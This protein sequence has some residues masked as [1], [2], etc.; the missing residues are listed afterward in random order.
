MR[1]QSDGASVIRW[2]EIYND[3]S[4][5]IPPYAV[6][7]VTGV[8]EGSNIFLVDQPNADSQREI[9][10]NGPI[11]VPAGFYGQAHRA[12]PC[13]VLYETADGTPASGEDWGTKNGSW[14]IHKGNTGFRILGNASDNLC[15]ATYLG[16]AGVS[17]LTVQEVDGSPTVTTTTLSFDQSDGL[18]VTDEGSGEARIDLVPATRTQAGGV[19]TNTQVWGGLKTFY[20]GA[21]GQYFQAVIP[22]DG[23]TVTKGGGLYIVTA[24]SGWT[25][26]GGV[27][28][29]DSS[30]SKTLSLVVSPVDGVAFLYQVGTPVVDPCYGVYK[31]SASA[32]KTGQWGT[33][34]DGSEVCG[35]LICSIGST[36]PSVTDGDYGDITVSSSGAV[37]TI[38]NDTVTYAKMQN[39]SAASKLLGRG[40]ASGAGDPEEITLGSGLSMSG[41]TLS[42]SGGGGLSDGDYGDVVVSSSGTVM[43]IDTNV[44]TYGKMQQS[45]TSSILLGRGVMGAGNLEEISLGSGLSMSGTTLNSYA[46]MTAIADVTGTAGSSYT[47]TEQAMINTLKAQLNTLLAYLRSNGLLAT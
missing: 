32:R 25:D 26:A 43:T 21:T 45:S 41:T 39:V 15:E 24:P 47:A 31:S 46:Q 22:Y 12:D 38:D 18:T 30:V 3:G 19:D 13:T 27:T 40:S 16:A 14:K 23:T 2:L 37:W 17:N 20:D 10:I 7:R 28:S 6:C 44:I 36:H 5:D 33:L 11:G 42:A 9:V 35:G 29:S 34:L 8:D 1:Q 4:D